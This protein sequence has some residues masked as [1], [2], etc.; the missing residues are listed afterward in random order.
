MIKHRILEITKLL[1]QIEIMLG[2]K[3]FNSTKDFLVDFIKGY[4]ELE[5]YFETIAILPRTKTISS[6]IQWMSY[7]SLKIRSIRF[8]PFGYKFFELFS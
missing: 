8:E 3:K 1:Q 5:S 7:I 4:Q 2:Q 6:A